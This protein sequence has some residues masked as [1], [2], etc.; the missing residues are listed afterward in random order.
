MFWN[1]VKIKLL[2]NNK[3]SEHIYKLRQEKDGILVELRDAIQEQERRMT[4]N[5]R[6]RCLNNVNNNT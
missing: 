3:L 5:G 4:K 6:G 1:K 2:S